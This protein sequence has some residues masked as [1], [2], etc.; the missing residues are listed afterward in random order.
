MNAGLHAVPDPVADAIAGAEGKPEDL[1]DMVG[2]IQM[3][4]STGR[5]AVLFVPRD[6]TALETLSLINGVLQVAEQL[7]AARAERGPIVPASKLPRS[8]RRRS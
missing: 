5:P 2:P 7:H 3:R 4:L 8:L 1:V 6:V